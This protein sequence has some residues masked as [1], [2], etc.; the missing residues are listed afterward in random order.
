MKNFIKLFFATILMLGVA[1]QINAQPMINNVPTVKLSNGVEMPL[2]GFGTLRLPQESCAEHVADA[3]KIGFR[4][5]DAAK[6]YA[7]E[8]EVGRGIKMSGVPRGQI[9][10]TTKLW[11]KDYGYESA[12]QA[13]E[14]SLERLGTDYVD[15]Y[16]LHQPFG[17]IHGAWRALEE[18]YEAG[19]IRAI[20]VSNFTPDRLV[21]L[22]LTARIQPMVNQIEFSPYFQQWQAKQWNDRYGVQV[23]AWGAMASGNR[24]EM[25]TEPTLVDIGKQYG[26]S[27][28]Q[29]ILRYLTQRGIVAL[30]RTDNPA[31]RQEDIDIFDFELTDAE[32]HA[33]DLLD[34]G[35][36]MAKDHR[37]PQDVE[38]FHTKATR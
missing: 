2:L 26:K 32:M 11:I 24:P 21:D 5:I 34:K 15:L 38:W 25:F 37:S 30:C 7:N 6:N 8:E 20:G 28:A 18:L 22:C 10:I 33:I 19:K 9:F 1:R 35:H 14:A 16:L 27:A 4:L 31:H 29:V 17:D 23:E 3:I 12:K 36:T 13:F